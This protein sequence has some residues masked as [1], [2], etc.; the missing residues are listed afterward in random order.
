MTGVSS[1]F[2][3]FPEGRIERIYLHWSAGDYTT[4]FPAYH[5]CVVYEN[6]RARTVETND[7]RSN[8][9]DV[10]AEPDRP[11]AAHTAGR[12]AFAAGLAIMGM[13]D[14]RPDH[15]GRFPMRDEAIDELCRIAAAI[16]AFYEILIDEEHV[17][18]H[19]EA[20][21]IDGYYGDAPDERW[22]IARLSP[23]PRPLEPAE[24]R[25]AGNALRDRI[26]VHRSAMAR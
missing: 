18:T 16:A 20:A 22:D 2:P 13:Q 24:A 10:R 6:G 23:S 19:A 14:A 1:S 17:M 3:Q 11:Y 26:R 5:F 25:A 7:L 9:R 12:N 15:F 21:L 4:L 8:M